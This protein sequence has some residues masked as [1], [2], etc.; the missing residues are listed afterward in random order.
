MILVFL[1]TNFCINRTL[2]VILQIVANRLPYFLDYRTHWSMKRS[3]NKW[4]LFLCITKRIKL[5]LTYKALKL[6]INL[7]ITV[8]LS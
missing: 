4:P 5:T 7:Y 2:L 3:I 6:L 1:A 8:P